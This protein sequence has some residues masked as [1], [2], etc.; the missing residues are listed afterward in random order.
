MNLLLAESDKRAISEI[1]NLIIQRENFVKEVEQQKLWVKER[2]RKVDVELAIIQK[3]TVR[4]VH[5][6]PISDF[7]MEAYFVMQMHVVRKSKKQQQKRIKE[8]CI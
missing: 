2:E 8:H 7:L 5:L 1:V 3:L 6:T 4:Y